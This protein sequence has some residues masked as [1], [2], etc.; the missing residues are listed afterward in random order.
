MLAGDASSL[1]TAALLQNRVQEAAAIG[2]SLVPD[3]RSCPNLDQ[4]WIVGGTAIPGPV[5]QRA[6]RG[7]REVSTQVQNI[8]TYKTQLSR[9]MRLPLPLICIMPM[10]VQREGGTS[11]IPNPAH[12]R[13]T[14]HLRLPVPDR[15]SKA[16]GPPEDCAHQQAALDT[17]QLCYR[18]LLHRVHNPPWPNVEETLQCRVTTNT[19]EHGHIQTI[20]WQ[21]CTGRGSPG[22]VSPGKVSHFTT[23]GATFSLN[24]RRERPHKASGN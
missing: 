5:M 15:P 21:S 9:C 19:D 1:L 4:G 24:I 16:T 20:A 8:A 17:Q 13:L 6:P 7:A 14:P 23:S 22:K 2:R 12:T 3:Q 11:C 18:P 10:R